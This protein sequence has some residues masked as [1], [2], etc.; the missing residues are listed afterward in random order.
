MLLLEQADL[1][2]ICSYRT[3]AWLTDRPCTVKGQKD[4]IWPDKAMLA[5]RTSLAFE[6][7]NQYPF[8][9]S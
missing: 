8:F 6:T 5:L 7:V 4:C 2:A 9:A 1:D 3:G